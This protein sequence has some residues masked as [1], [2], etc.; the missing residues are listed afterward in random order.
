[1]VS[2]SLVLK[3]WDIQYQR[4][5]LT[6][7]DEPRPVSLSGADELGRAVEDGDEVRVFGRRFGCCAA[8]RRACEGSFRRR[9]GE[10]G[11]PRERLAGPEGPEEG[12]AGVHRGIGGDA[13]DLR[14]VEEEGRVEVKLDDVVSMGPRLHWSFFYV[15]GVWSKENPKENPNQTSI[16]I[17]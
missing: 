7:D 4:R 9:T 17:T 5:R 8:R 2:L 13:V 3:H 10:T 1:M 11:A 12:L 16:I 6:E 14:V 15:Q